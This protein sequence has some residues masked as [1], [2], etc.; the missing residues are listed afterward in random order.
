MSTSSDI[1]PRDA[2]IAELEAR[3]LELEALVEHMARR[4][5]MDSTNSSRPPSTDDKKARSLRKKRKSSR[6]RGGQ[7]SHKGSKREL[8]EESRVDHF[9]DHYPDACS[10]G[11]DLGQ[12]HATGHFARHQRFEL[13]PQLIECT[14]RRFHTCACPECGKKVAAKPTAQQRLGWGPRLTA[15][16]ATMSVALHATRGKLDWFAGVNGQEQ[17]EACKHNLCCKVVHLVWLPNFRRPYA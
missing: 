16:L 9:I 12:E 4:L 2:R 10:C 6:Q 17:V 3:V 13:P 11:H 8:W 14:E 1:D 5:G 15:L 7:P